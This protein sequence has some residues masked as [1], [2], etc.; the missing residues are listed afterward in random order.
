[1]RI[2]VTG[3]NGR[4][5][6]TVV[7]ELAEA[8]HAVTNLDLGPPV[9]P[10][11]GVATMRGN[12]ANA[13]DVYG[14]VAYSGAE[15]VVH[16]AAWADPGL[17]ADHRTYADN[18]AGTFNI[19]DVCHSLKVR[20]V[21]VASSAQV[22]GFAGR[23]P[24]YA[25][26]DEDHPLRPLNSY[27]LAKI[28]GEQAAGY[29][30]AKGL[31]VLSLRIM[32]ARA[33]ETIAAEVAAMKADPAGDRR[34][35]WTRTDARDIAT[36]CR[37]ALE[38]EEVPSGVYNLTAARNALGIPTGELLA[39]HFPETALRPGLDGDR[40]GLSIAKAQAAFGYAPRFG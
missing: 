24:A 3:G 33:P 30:I 4:V 5:G 35:L 6:R 36:G 14:A 15:A 9:S 1:M 27:A 2:L 12:V 26:V 38:R 7:S 40:S 39:R 25:P 13:A 8:G 11:A 37:Q 16:L 17:V 19:L 10:V 20:R 31:N 23:A 21:I 32:G 34:L 18:T 28:A 29:F 22:Y